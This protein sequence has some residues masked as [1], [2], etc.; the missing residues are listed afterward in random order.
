MTLLPTVLKYSSSAVSPR[1]LLDPG[2]DFSGMIGFVLLWGL[3]IFKI[4]LPKVKVRLF[5]RY[6]QSFFPI[7]KILKNVILVPLFL[8]LVN[9]QSF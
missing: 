6:L 8:K 9:K 7:Y 2:F 3:V 5:I 4:I 1:N